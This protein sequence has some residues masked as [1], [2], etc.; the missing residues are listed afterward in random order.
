MMLRFDIASIVFAL[1]INNRW[2]VGHSLLCLDD[3]NQL[4][5]HEKGIICIAALSDKGIRRPFCNGEILP[6]LRAGAIRVTEMIGV[7]LPAV[8]AELIVNQQTSLSL[9][10]FHAL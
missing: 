10:K 6:F 3:S 1:V 5:P 2:N 9:R 4:Q 7:S 8:F